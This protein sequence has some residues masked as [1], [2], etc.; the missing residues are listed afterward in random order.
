MYGVTMP[1]MCNFIFCLLLLHLAG[2]ENGTSVKTCPAPE[3]PKNAE[4]VGNNTIGSRV[5]FLCKEGFFRLGR[6]P[7]TITCQSNGQWTKHNVS[8]VAVSCGDPGNS[9]QW[10]T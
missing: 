5:K 10:R 7:F 4:A 2:A 3:A 9:L 8:C 1:R 6:R